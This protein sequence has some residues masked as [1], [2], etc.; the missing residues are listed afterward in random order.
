MCVY[1]FSCLNF[2]GTALQMLVENRIT[3]FPVIDDDWKLVSCFLP[4]SLYE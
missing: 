4:Q 1:F 2:D 3:G